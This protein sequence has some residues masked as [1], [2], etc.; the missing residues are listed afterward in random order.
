VVEAPKHVQLVEDHALIAPHHLLQDNLDGD[1]AIGALS[2]ADD[3]ICTCAQSAPEAVL[4]LLIVAFGL[5]M[6]AVEHVRDYN[7]IAVSVCTTAGF[8][9]AFREK[10]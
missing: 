7:E 3:A 6:E 4:G 2:L 1:A 8:G 9:G 10:G 5:P